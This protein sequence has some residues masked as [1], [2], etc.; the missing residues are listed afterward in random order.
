MIVISDVHFAQLKDLKVGDIIACDYDTR[1]IVIEADEKAKVWKYKFLDG[2]ITTL[3]N[4]SPNFK[5]PLAIIA[6]NESVEEA[7]KS[8][9]V[10]YNKDV[11][12]LSK[13]LDTETGHIS[14]AI[15]DKMLTFK[16]GKALW[17][18]MV[19]QS[20][21]TWYERYEFDYNM[22]LDKWDK[23]DESIYIERNMEFKRSN[24][25]IDNLKKYLKG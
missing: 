9:L 6:H 15:G 24:K 4:E 1:A 22:R 23:I 19:E 21:D 20:G 7:R 16:E 5:I 13:I 25:V 2:I 10:N 12:K 11:V 18:Y 14:F 8:R 17:D 3:D